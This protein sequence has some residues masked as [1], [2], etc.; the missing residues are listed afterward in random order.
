MS[1]EEFIIMNDAKKILASIV[2]RVKN[3][4]KTIGK[5][6]DLILQQDFDGEFE[7]VVID[8]GST[9]NTISEAEKRNCRIFKI[10]PEEFTWGYA[11]NLGA[12]KSA[13]EFV[14]YLSGHCFPADRNWLKN[15]L[16]PFNNE[17]I[18]AVYSRQIPCPDGDFFEAVELVYL[19]FPKNEKDLKEASFSN[20]SC[21]IRKSILEKI[22]FDPALPYCEDGEWA[23]RV[24]QAGLL[25]KYEPQSLI[26]H[27][28]E[29]KVE[30]IYKRWFSRALG[31]TQISGKCRDGDIF[32][33]F[34][35]TLKFILLDV[36]YLIKINKIWLIWKIPF[37]EAVRQIA[38]F[39]GA[40]AYK[41][42]KQKSISDIQIP[43]YLKWIKLVL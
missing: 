25:I 34:Y 30:V 36:K 17:N 31:G 41:I 13:G 4:G 38:A 20:G 7:I 22:K 8:S 5:V 35:K 14:V 28:H 19:W 26:Y 16:N 3:E 37:Y 40:R 18:A 2:L 42:H 29:M 43:F 6:L 1:G 9:D 32:Y 33:L 24:R 15:L 23:N 10:K 12:E 11:L 39:K 27:S 21:A